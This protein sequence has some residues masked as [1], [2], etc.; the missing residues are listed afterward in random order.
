VGACIR[1][2]LTQDFDALA[3]RTV[4]FSSG[5]NV[6]RDAER[7]A[8]AVV[9]TVACEWSEAAGRP[10]GAAVV[11]AV[12]D[13]L[14]A[15]GPSLKTTLHAPVDA[16]TVLVLTHT[17][18][19]VKALNTALAREVA[20]Q[21]LEDGVFYPGL[22]Y[23]VEAP[24]GSVANGDTFLLLGAEVVSVHTRVVPTKLL[25][26]PPEIPA[27]ATR[28]CVV[29]RYRPGKPRAERVLLRLF[30]RWLDGGPVLRP[31]P[32]SV[33][34]LLLR[35]C[36]VDLVTPHDEKLQLPWQRVGLGYAST[37]FKSQGGQ[38]DRVVVVVPPA[39]SF[40]A[41]AR[42]L[43]VGV[44]RAKSQLVILAG[45]LP[46]ADG[47]LSRRSALGRMILTPLKPRPDVL[48][49]TLGAHLAG[50][51]PRAVFTP[52]RVYDP[53]AEAVEAMEAVVAAERFRAK[54][55][56]TARTHASDPASSPAPAPAPV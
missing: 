17:N 22:K 26:V 39:A 10:D 36:T 40:T 3:G 1:E 56:V 2:V 20:G 50:R 13:T 31:R 33:W 52:F 51:D 38:G 32:G 28:P 21:S 46:S 23:V 54:W 6:W 29:P 8:G 12:V 47:A 19:T 18:D 24:A 53:V 5:P 42:V 27:S 9:E 16:S 55:R 30:V 11:R 35:T 15:A 7:F 45:Q 34:V 37:K 14:K 25:V 49:A 41:D 48:V 4:P 44:S 43:Y